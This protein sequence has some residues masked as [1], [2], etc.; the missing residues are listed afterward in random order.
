MGLTTAV[1]TS[2]P[3]VA[4]PR[5]PVF[6]Q[7]LCPPQPQLKGA[8]AAPTPPPSPTGT[9]KSPGTGT[10]PGLARRLLG[11]E[12][13][14]LTRWHRF[15]RLLHRPQ[16]PAALGAFRAAFGLLMALDVPQERGLGHLDQRYL[17]GLEVCRF[18]LLPFLAPL[19][20]DWIADEADTG[21]GAAPAA[22]PAGVPA[23]PGR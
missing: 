5:V 16:D 14:E 21:P 22:R 2:H 3:L 10:G 11:F 9:P 15:V 6:P 12:L 13:R 18:P 19:P 8:A 23:A 17:D 20:L 7:T 4:P 1:G